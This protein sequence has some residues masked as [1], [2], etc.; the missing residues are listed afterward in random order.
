MSRSSASCT[1]APVDLPTRT[2]RFT[3]TGDGVDSAF[4]GIGEGTPV[5]IL[6]AVA[7]ELIRTVEEF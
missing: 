5:V 7:L 3:T 1:Y 2:I 6:A 4:W